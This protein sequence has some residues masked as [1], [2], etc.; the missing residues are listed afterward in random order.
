MHADASPSKIILGNLIQFG[1]NLGKI[2]ARFEQIEV[3]FGQK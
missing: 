2:K 3:K 1:R